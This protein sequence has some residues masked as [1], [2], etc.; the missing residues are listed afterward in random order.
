MGM[1]F[2][3]LKV[4]RSHLVADSLDE[5]CLVLI[6]LYKVAFL[7]YCFL[8]WIDFVLSRTDLYSSIRDGFLSVQDR[9]L[10]ICPGWIFSYLSRTDFHSSI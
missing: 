2:L 7:N 10:F 3:N 9:L 4:R 8:P 5:V 6:S 1:L